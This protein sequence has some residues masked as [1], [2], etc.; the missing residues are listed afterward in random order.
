VGWQ[1]ARQIIRGAAGSQF[2]PV[3]V[4]AY[5]SVPDEAFARIRDGIA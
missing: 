3:I 5:D 2:D 4:A 1:E